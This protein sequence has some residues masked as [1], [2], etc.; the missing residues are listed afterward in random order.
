LRKYQLSSNKSRA[1]IN[2]RVKR[3]KHLRVKQN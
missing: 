2:S 1:R 3:I